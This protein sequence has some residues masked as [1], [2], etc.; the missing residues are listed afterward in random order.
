MGSLKKTF[1]HI[2]VAL[3]LSTVNSD[4][5]SSYIYLKQKFSKIGEEELHENMQ[6]ETIQGTVEYLEQID[7]TTSEEKVLQ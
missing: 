4:Y 6:N 1:R 7:A 5:H 2:I 3:L